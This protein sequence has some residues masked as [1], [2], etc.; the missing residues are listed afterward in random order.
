MGIRFYCPNGHKLNV[1]SFQAGK[2]GICPYCGAKIEIPTQSTRPGS[3]EEKQQLQRE[4]AQA[5]TEGATPVAGPQGGVPVGGL[6]DEEATR[7]TTD[8]PEGAPA[9]PALD[10]EAS[11]PSAEVMVPDEAAVAAPLEVPAVDVGAAPAAAESVTST[12]G[13][14][15]PLAEAPHVVWYV[16]APGGGQFGPAAADVMRNW[17][18][19][20][21]VSPDSLVWREGWR[22]WQEASATFR[23]LGGG[24][25]DPSPADIVPEKRSLA[26]RSTGRRHGISRRRSGRPRALLITALILAVIVLLCLL[27]WVLTRKPA[28]ESTGTGAK[29]ESIVHAEALRGPLLPVPRHHST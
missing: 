16:R 18:S 1:K 27:I 21:R 13:G 24:V 6:P 10:P 12:P 26:A 15:D 25:Q 19:E 20:G 3:K 23:E 11:M 14:S 7:G 2:R 5:A 8:I 22:D 29:A 4:E 28:E 9:R 17:I